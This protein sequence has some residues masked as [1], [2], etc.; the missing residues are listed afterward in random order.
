M[1]NKKTYSITALSFILMNIVAFCLFYIPNF[2]IID[3][4]DTAYEIW[5][6]ITAFATKFSD[7]LLP[8]VS[9]TVLLLGYERL[10]TKKTLLYALVFSVPR[11]FYIL[12]YYYLQFW[13]YGYDSIEAISFS[14]LAS[15]LGIAVFFGESVL[16]LYVIR[17][18]ARLPIL[19]ELKK[20][21][22]V[23]LRTN[24]PKDVMTNLKRTADGLIMSSASES[25]VFDLDS[26]IIFG[27]LAAAFA[28][29]CISLIF[30]LWDFVGYLIEYA[31]DYRIGE[32]AELTAY[33]VFLAIELL[34]THAICCFIKNYTVKKRKD[35]DNG[36]HK[37]L[38]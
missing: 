8:V 34:A 32:I 31:G 15:L 18:F 29:F 7:F 1:T 30:E 26:P 3:L 33:L 28:E 11:I 22:P 5:R 36:I 38:E 35:I 17:I 37:T 12:P 20:D 2:L 23:N 19:K 21:L 4:S 6:L 27:I 25:R 14:A 10:G 9:A 16:L 24:T 13:I